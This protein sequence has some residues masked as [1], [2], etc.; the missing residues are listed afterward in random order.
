MASADPDFRWFS[1][2]NRGV[3][4]DHGYIVTAL[5]VDFGLALVTLALPSNDLFPQDIDTRDTA[6]GTDWPVRPT[7]TQPY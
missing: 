3:E 2:E 7:H 6:T 5:P 4:F 1:R